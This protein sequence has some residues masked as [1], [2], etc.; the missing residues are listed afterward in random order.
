MKK[1]TRSQARYL[2]VE[3][4]NIARRLQVIT[5]LLDAACPAGGP[6]SELDAEFASPD[7]Q[8][9]SEALLGAVRKVAAHLDLDAEDILENA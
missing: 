4:K 6:P 5:T 8:D 7:G 9:Y 1:L 2:L 3:G